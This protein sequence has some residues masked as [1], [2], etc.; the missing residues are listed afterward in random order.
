MHVDHDKN[1]LHDSYIIDFVHDAI[2]NY[3]ER[4]KYGCR[5]FH[6][7]KTP[8]FMLKVLKLFLFY[9]AMLVTMCL[10]DLFV[11]KIPMHRKWVRLKCVSYFLLDALFYFNSYSCEYIFL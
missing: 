10:F 2:E 4:G 8:L 9:L 7:T 11:Y 6:P 1:V 3:F 5:N